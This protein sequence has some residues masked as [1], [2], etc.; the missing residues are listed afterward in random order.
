MPEDLGPKP[1]KSLAGSAGTWLSSILSWPTFAVL[2]VFIFWKPL[3][4]VGELLPRL[5]ENSDTITLGKLTLQVRQNLKTLESQAGS[6]VRDALSGMEAEDALMVLES[7]LQGATTYSGD[8]GE[9]V[10]KWRKLQRLGMVEELTVADLRKE[11]KSR[12][13]KP[14]EYT[15]G[16][17]PTGKYDKVHKFLARAVFEIANASIL[18]SSNSEKKQ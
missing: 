16:V 7:N 8:A 2:L 6:D 15:F 4:Q 12:G 10:R 18:S 1:S 13:D 3:H 9:D 14:G 11:E 5:V 17:R